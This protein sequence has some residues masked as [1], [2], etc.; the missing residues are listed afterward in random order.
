MASQIVFHDVVTLQQRTRTHGYT[1][2]ALPIHMP[3]L[4]QCLKT[5]FP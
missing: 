4:H 1:A 5:S 2:C 3:E